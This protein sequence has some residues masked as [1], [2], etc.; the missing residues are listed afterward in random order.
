VRRPVDIKHQFVE[1]IPDVL[2]DG[3][4][5]VSIAFATAV[6]R[7]F[8]GC[9]SEVVTPLSPTDW[10]LAFDGKT[11]SLHPSVGSWSLKCR[12]HY[13]VRRNRVEWAPQWSQEQIE[14]ERARDRRAKRA[15]YEGTSIE[16]RRGKISGEPTSGGWWKKLMGKRR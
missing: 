14:T 4:L 5:Y 15:H 13:W 7:C 16:D 9:G 2:E 8:C 10:E 12:S 3:T 11:V 1:Y 6:H